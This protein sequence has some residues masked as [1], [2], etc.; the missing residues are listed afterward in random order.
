MKE[1]RER[2]LIG[3]HPWLFSGAVSK[4][5]GRPEPGEIVVATTKE[6]QPLALGFY[7][8]QS[9]IAFRMLTRDVAA[10]VD[11]GF[12]QRRL[13][14][15]ADLRK[16]IL[17]SDTTAFRLINAEG[18]GMPGLVVDRYGDYLVMVISTAGVEKR[19][20]A[21]IA[22]LGDECRPLGILER[23]D[24]PARRLEGL[25]DCTGWVWG[26]E[27]PEGISIRENGLAFEVDIR[28]GQKTGFFLDQRDNRSRI[29]GLSRGLSVLN[30]FSYTGAF[31]VYAARG[32]AKRVVS[33][34]ASE[35]ANVAARH[36]L[37]IN[38][39]SVAAHPVLKDD[40]F[41]YLRKTEE[42]Y[43]LIILDPPAF[44]KNR[45]EVQH[46]ARGYKDINLQAFRRLSP[47]G[48]LATF[49]CS[50]AIDEALFEKI[51]LGAARDAGKTV[52]LLKR[53]AASPDHPTSLAHSEGRYLKGLLVNA[54]P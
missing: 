41:Q 27:A 48:L 9:D 2:S 46:A 14:D 23:S 44:A 25:M 19:R 32:G 26:E 15:A 36:H 12:W 30:C 53:L 39:F 6:G 38:G 3:G 22:A 35:P 8:S 29:G 24:G 50:N 47:G 31:S 5:K 7:N 43:D 51:V 10:T 1:G 37:E 45:K 49:S 52:R 34:D 21:V 11:Q 20:E 33:V 18:D 17:A 54:L 16:R 40:V 4:I 42:S 28:T 13:R